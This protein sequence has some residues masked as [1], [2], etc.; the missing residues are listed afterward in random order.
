MSEEQFAYYS[1]II[2]VGGLIIYMG[3]IIYDLAKKSKAGRFGMMILF[4]GLFTGVLGFVI[5]TVLVEFMGIGAVVL[6]SGGLC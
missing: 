3:F 4:I 5:K 2:L 6:I 1:T